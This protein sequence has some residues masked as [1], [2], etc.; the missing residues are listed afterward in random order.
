VASIP[1]LVLGIGAGWLYGSA[2]MMTFGVLTL[3]SWRAVS[4]GNVTAALVIWPIAALY[5]LFGA[6]A[7]L[8]S[9]FE[10][11]FL[12]LS[13]LARSRRLPRML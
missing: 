11:H 7:Y 8:N 9:S 12:G 13:R 10:R 1:K 3:M 2:A 5:L 6:A 4:R